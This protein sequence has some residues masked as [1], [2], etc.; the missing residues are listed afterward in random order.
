MI[1]VVVF[2]IDSIH[3]YVI[4]FI[5]QFQFHKGACIKAGQ[6]DPNNSSS[7]LSDCDIYGSANA[8]NAIT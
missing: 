5:L 2:F 8:G 7:V 3:R 1:I 4:S 6:Y